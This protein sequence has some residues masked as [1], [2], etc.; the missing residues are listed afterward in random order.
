MKPK[1]LLVIRNSALGDVAMTAPVLQQL[2]QQYPELRLTVVTTPA[3]SPIFAPLE[4]TDVIGLDKRGRHKGFFGI[5]KLFQEL[6]SANRFDAIA[7]LHN[8]L[9]STILRNLFRLTGIPVAKIDKGRKEKKEL[10]RKENKKL[11]Q[12]KTS[13]QRYADVFAA[14]GFPVKLDKEVQP[15]AKQTLPAAAAS[16]FHPGKIHIGI[17]PFAKHG[18]KMYPVDK[19]LLVI[20]Q[21][22]SADQ[23][24]LFLLGG[25]KEEVKLLNEWAEQFPGIINL[26]GKFSF[27]EELAIISNLDKMISMDSAN[28]HLASLFGVPVV[29]IWGATHPYAGFYGWGQKAEH[30]AQVDL[31]CRPCSVFGNKPC[32]RG[33]HACMEQLP[34]SLVMEKVF[35]I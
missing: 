14:L 29:S 22:H 31:Y 32:Y 17:A 26:A 27:S 11:V 5:Y 24:Q 10:T 20:Q 1:H 21:L 25:G 2:L 23:H 7:D 30:A 6:R 33:D 8:V 19:M 12:L 9:R 3:F 18:E 16:L 13:F 34:E 28:M 4:R 15:Y 35:Q